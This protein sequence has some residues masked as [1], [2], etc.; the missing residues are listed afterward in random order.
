MLKSLMIR[1]LATVAELDVEFGQGLNVLTGETGAG[2]SIIL[3]ALRVLLGE[4]AEKSLIRKGEPRC[5]ISAVIRVPGA[6]DA[7]GEDLAEIL[8][9]AG[10]PPCENGDLLLRRTITANDTRAFINATPVTLQVMR[11]LGDILID[12]HG[13]NDH[14][15]LLRP[16]CQLDLL[17]TFGDLADLRAACKQCFDAREA[18]RGNVAELEA[19]HITPAE[20]ELLRHQVREIDGAELSPDE[21]ETLVNRHRVASNARRLLEIASQCQNG[22]AETEGCVCDELGQYVRLLAEVRDTAPEKGADFLARL[23]EC[24]SE[25]QEL[26]GDLAAF[27]ES[28]ELDEQELSFLEERLDLIQ[29]LKRRYG[30]EI[31]DVL[32]KGEEMREKL[33]AMENREERVAAAQ[34]ELASATRR[35][36]AAC[37]KLTGARRAAAA[38]LAAAIGEKLCALGFAQGQFTV[39][40]HPAEPGDKGAD[41]VEFCFAPNVGEDLLPLRK[42][43]SSGEIAR[44]M[45]AVKTVLTAVDRVP[46]LIFDE[47]DANIGGRVARC[48]ANELAAVSDH[49][50]VFCITHLAQ[51]AAAAR[52]HFV[53]D[54]QTR[55]GRTV[56]HIGNLDDAGRVQE[57]SRMMGADGE[58]ATACQHAREM[59]TAR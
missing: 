6:S 7:T 10:V 4:R 16:R 34:E 14:Q 46:I 48:V 42:I 44:V 56:T 41:S 31:S 40:C 36:R 5:E 28:L 37:E 20:K 12:I 29:K 21:E 1:N 24:V 58:S 22:L 33:A 39:Q 8:D 53:V 26:S 3:G 45:L 49:H 54:K 35:H 55:N 50:Q 17:D 2:K 30:G 13:P 25:L 23:E 38:K 19:Q 52:R 32:A 51:I 47:V 43:A 57:L 27:A 59:L 15:S 9:N 11:D 18:C